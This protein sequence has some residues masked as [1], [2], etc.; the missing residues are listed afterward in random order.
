MMLAL[1]VAAIASMAA[2]PAKVMTYT[3]P[4]TEDLTLP[5]GEGSDLAATNCAACHSLDYIRSQPRGKG[6]QFWADEVHK[7]IAVYGAP[8]EPADEKIIAAYLVKTYGEP[9]S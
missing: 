7:M 3:L 2:T 6:A 4:D 9:T 1:P 8:I 5:A